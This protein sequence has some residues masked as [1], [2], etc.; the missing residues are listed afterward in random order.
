MLDR[1]FDEKNYRSIVVKVTDF[2]FARS[3]YTPYRGTLF[4]RV[5]HPFARTFCGTEAYSSPELLRGKLSYNPL[6][7]DLWSLGVILYEMLSGHLPFEHSSRNPNAIP[8]AQKLGA[9]FDPQ[10]SKYVSPLAI[11]L[12]VGM[13]QYNPE[14]RFVMRDVLL[15]PFVYEKFV[16]YERSRLAS[17]PT[18][19]ARVEASLVAGQ[20]F[21]APYRLS[22][23]CFNRVL[24]QHNIYNASLNP[25]APLNAREGC[26]RLRPDV[27]LLEIMPR[28]PRE[29]IFVNAVHWLLRPLPPPKAA[30]ED[31]FYRQIGDDRVFRCVKRLGDIFKSSP[32]FPERQLLIEIMDTLLTIQCISS[33]RGVPA[34]QD[35]LSLLQAFLCRPTSDFAMPLLQR[36][37][38]TLC[39]ALMDLQTLHNRL[40]TVVDSGG[41]TM[42]G[43]HSMST[44]DRITED[45]AGLKQFN[46]KLHG[47]IVEL[48][49]W[50][51]RSDPGF[52]E[53][54][55]GR[56]LDS[57][58]P[59]FLGPCGDSIPRT[60]DGRAIVFGSDGSHTEMYVPVGNQ[61][62][63]AFVEADIRA[64][65]EKYPPDQRVKWLS[66][67]LVALKNGMPRVER[68]TRVLHKSVQFTRTHEVTLISPHISKYSTSVQCTVAFK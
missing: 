7:N 59:I 27:Q 49:M 28:V 41:Y 40:Q 33:T 35:A 24:E 18:L 42:M 8:E 56:L 12:I 26:V 38:A 51:E 43:T 11:D 20:N 62:M 61:Q 68:D 50:A 53:R 2:G 39:S 54:T 10:W 47:L 22:A 63:R 52:L 32:E 65:A 66:S 4:R 15:H 16:Q 14:E 29:E 57:G 46:E 60:P 25:T 19:A 30:D 34:V 31:A 36:T 48:D 58:P 5:Q 37:T 13:L 64:K 17:C 6:V 23:D 3:A 1:P 45:L 44:F 9:Q 21:I 67:R 55:L